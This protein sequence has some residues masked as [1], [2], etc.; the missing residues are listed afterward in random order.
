MD[1]T[2]PIP[3]RSSRAFALLLLVVAAMH[4]AAQPSRG[5]REQRALRKSPPIHLKFDEARLVDRALVDRIR[6]ERG[7]L[8]VRLLGRSALVSCGTGHSLRALP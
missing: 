4:A 7:V 6:C 1:R 5:S 2:E 8:I 3:R